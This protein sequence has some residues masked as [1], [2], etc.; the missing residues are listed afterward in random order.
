MLTKKQ[1]AEKLK[2]SVY[3]IDRL[4]KKGLPAVKVGSN[5]RFDYEDVAKWLKEGK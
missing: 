3:T 2:V 5:I 4:R 1:L